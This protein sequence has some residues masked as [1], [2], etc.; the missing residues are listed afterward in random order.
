MVL[1]YYQKNYMETPGIP[2]FWPRK[3]ISRNAMIYGTLQSNSRWTRWPNGYPMKSAWKIYSMKG[4]FC[5]QQMMTQNPT[6]EKRWSAKLGSSRKTGSTGS[7]FQT[8]NEILPTRFIIELPGN[9][10]TWI[11][12]ESETA[13]Q[14][15]SSAITPSS[16]NWNTSLKMS[17]RLKLWTSRKL[18]MLIAGIQVLLI[19]ISLKLT[20]ERTFYHCGRTPF[21]ECPS[22]AM[23]KTPIYCIDSKSKF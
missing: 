21:G 2:Y 7:S 19:L 6:M 23:N 10:W 3:F 16:G 9:I 1:I 5:I 14:L 8:W 15:W 22:G 11:W 20:P 17:W 12:R 13:D 18:F 4:N